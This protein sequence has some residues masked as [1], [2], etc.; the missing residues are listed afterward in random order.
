M[1]ELPLPPGLRP[2]GAADFES[3]QEHRLHNLSQLKS[4]EHMRLRRQRQVERIC[5]TPRLV[6]ELLDELD[7]HHDRGA[8]LDWRLE[9]YSSVDPVVLA[10]VG[11]DRFAPLP[12]RAVG[13]GR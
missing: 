7:R 8:D 11:G 13:C 2:G 9:R 6:F 1:R 3:G 4:Q 5:C 12:L 10:E